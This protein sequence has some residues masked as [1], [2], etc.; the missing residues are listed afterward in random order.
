MKIDF[1]LIKRAMGLVKC[2]NGHEVNLTLIAN[3]DGVK[4]S[5]DF[6]CKDLKKAYDA[7]FKRQSSLQVKKGLDGIF[8]SA[9]G[10]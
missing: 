9:F 4:V 10:R 3:K 7:E 2:P 5:G 8:R 1:I 6:C